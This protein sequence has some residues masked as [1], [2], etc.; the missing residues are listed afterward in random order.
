MYV[1][2]LAFVAVCCAGLLWQAFKPVD[3]VAVSCGGVQ[4]FEGCPVFSLCFLFRSRQQS[5]SLHGQA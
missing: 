5:L 2:A 4:L 1:G 3:M